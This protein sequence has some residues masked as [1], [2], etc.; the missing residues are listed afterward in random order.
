MNMYSM[1]ISEQPIDSRFRDKF[2]S[3]AHLASVERRQ[4][5]SDTKLKFNEYERTGKSIFVVTLS[6]FVSSEKIAK[7]DWMR[8][9]W[10]RDFLYRVTEQLPH[11]LKGKIDFD[12]VIERSPDGKYHYHGLLAMPREAGDRIWKNGV[13][14]KELDKDLKAL[15]E[16]GQHRKFAVNSFLIE[17]IRVGQTVDH[18][19]N[20]MTKTRDYIASKEW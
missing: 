3:Q 13:L 6:T 12:Y 15:R 18:W 7:S 20:Y 14:N 2:I 8:K 19:I 11:V 1:N 9:F 5:A 4:F 16:K 17:P 10:D